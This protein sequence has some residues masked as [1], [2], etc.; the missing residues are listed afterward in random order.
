M[1]LS[2]IGQ[3]AKYAAHYTI[4]YLIPA[5]LLVSSGV[6]PKVG[7]KGPG[8]DLYDIVE[9]VIADEVSS[10]MND[11]GSEAGLHDCVDIV[12]TENLDL[13]LSEGQSLEIDALDEAGGDEE[14]AGAIYDELLEDTGIDVAYE[15]INY[16]GGSDDLVK[17]FWNG[18]L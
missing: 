1:F 3:L 4:K 18:Q 15:I 8:G 5:A 7:I 16:Y 12:M 10:A 13:I 6:D 11:L 14:M 17:R 9:G 2:I